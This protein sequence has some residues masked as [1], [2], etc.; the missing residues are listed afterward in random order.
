MT[1]ALTVLRLTLRKPANHVLPTAECAEKRAQESVTMVAASSSTSS[2]LLVL[3]PH[4]PI[5]V[6]AARLPVV[7]SV[8]FAPHTTVSLLA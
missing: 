6:T 2:Q 3:A 1:A 4:V 5:I 7:G 8:T